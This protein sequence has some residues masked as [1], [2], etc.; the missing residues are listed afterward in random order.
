LCDFLN[1]VPAENL[2]GLIADIID[3]LNE[4]VEDEEATNIEDCLN[5]V[6]GIDVD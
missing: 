4:V 2:P 1:Q 3:A 6:F 5:G